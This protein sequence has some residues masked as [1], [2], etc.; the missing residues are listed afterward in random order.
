MNDFPEYIGLDYKQLLDRV[1][2]IVRA[3]KRGPLGFRRLTKERSE[4][5]D[6]RLAYLYQQIAVARTRMVGPIDN[7]LM[8]VTG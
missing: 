7:E 6:R 3:E 8:P 5:A 2:R 1:D 4:E